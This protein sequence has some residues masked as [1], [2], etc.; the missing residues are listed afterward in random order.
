MEKSLR[1]ACPFFKKDPASHMRGSCS[2]PG[3]DSVH[4][5]KEHIYRAHS[6]PLRCPRCSEDVHDHQ[7]LIEHLKK[8]DQCEPNN[9]P[10]ASSSV[11]RNDNGIS[12]DQI[13]RLRKLSQRGRTQC[14]KWRG[15]YKFL[16]QVEDDSD[17]PSPFYEPIIPEKSL[18]D[19]CQQRFLV[20]METELN[21][22]VKE[23]MRAASERLNQRIPEL[24]RMAQSN[25]REELHRIDGTAFVQQTLLPGGPS[26]ASQGSSSHSVE[27][28]S[29]THRKTCHAEKD[30]SESTSQPLQP[31]E[32]S[33][34]LGSEGSSYVFPE[35][36]VEARL[37]QS[38]LP[39]C[40]GASDGEQGDSNG[41]A[42]HIDSNPGLSTHIA[43]G[44]LS[45][46]DQHAPLQTPDQ[47]QPDDDTNNY[48]EWAQGLSDFLDLPED[49][50]WFSYQPK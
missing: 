37:Y 8:V 5:V 14:E 15:V 22:A 38:D 32:D 43:D 2:G 20:V 36:S 31:D 49:F 4:R 35:S 12:Q 33:S 50:D 23:E 26:S 16:F 7:G 21:R 6:L 40:C 18:V 41:N 45:S 24:L 47:I 39:A 13:E 3:W 10:M 48:S 11:N 19:V 44:T 46:Q 1:L 25:I 34:C 28:N 30:L 29:V 42:E 27:Q 17:I 9:E